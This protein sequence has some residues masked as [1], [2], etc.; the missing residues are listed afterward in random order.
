MNKI[1]FF[2]ITIASAL[3]I[4][5]NSTVAYAAQQTMADGSVV[6]AE[7]LPYDGAA[8]PIIKRSNV[9]EGLIQARKRVIRDLVVRH[10]WIMV[11]DPALLFDADYYASLY[12]EVASVVGTDYKSLYNHYVNTGIYEG[13]SARLGYFSER[14]EIK[15]HPAYSQ[16]RF[17]QQIGFFNNNLKCIDFLQ[18]KV[19]D[20]MSER[21]VVTVIHDE[22]CNRMCYGECATA[23]GPQTD[24][25]AFLDGRCSGTCQTY[26]CVFDYMCRMV[27]IESHL[28]G[29]ISMNHGWNRVLIDG[30][31]YDIDVTWD[32]CL[33]NKDYF[34]TPAGTGAFADRPVNFIDSW[35]RIDMYPNMSFED[36][37]AYIHMLNSTVSY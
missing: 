37:V 32:D 2:A 35:F 19:N 17:L 7:Y 11:K 31:W 29:S 5:G 28:V 34:L 33:S 15:L 8:M 6:D 20:S 18:S 25:D 22:I 36:A 21:E 14:G 24:M 10:T 16:E 1:K 27:G 26:S 12:P 9:S 13:R 30:I 3:T 23:V 4:I